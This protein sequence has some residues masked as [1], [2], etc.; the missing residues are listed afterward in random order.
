MKKGHSA[1]AL[2]TVLVA[3][4]LGSLNVWSQESSARTAPVHL[5]VTVEARHGTEMPEVGKEDVMVYQGKDR[6]Q[7]TEWVPYQGEQAG[8]EFFILL[9][10]SLNTDVGSRL[11]DL[12]K[13]ITAQPP[14]TA[15]GVAY[16]RNGAGEIAQ[17]LTTDHAQAAKALRLPLGEAGV[18]ASPY[19]SIQDLIKK[20]PVSR[21]RREMLVISDGIDRL[22][23]F[24][25][26]NPYV[27]SAIATAQRAGVIIYALYARGAGHFGHT[28]WRVN[29]G[30]TYLS[31]VTDET[32]GEAY[33]L[34]LE[35]PV[36]FQ[37]YLEDLS[38]RL[39]HQF[40]L[41]FLARAPKKAGLQPVK[42]RAEEPNAEL[43]AADRVYVPA[44]SQ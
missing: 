9:D 42:L 10:D 39:T 5:V 4:T 35:T 27:D 38:L 18:N 34:G 33:F 43:V 41:G 26:Q 13:F 7:V 40:H 15:I 30:Q 17:N 44:A 19:F 6:D 14:T 31:Q 22:G 36:S 24:G 3:A 16:M 12:R 21:Q 8:L 11:D 28:F 2:L 20:W 29:W 1:M 23:G 25:L 32:G 37:P